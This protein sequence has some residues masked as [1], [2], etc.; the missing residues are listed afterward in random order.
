M[1]RFVD[2]TSSFADLYGRGCCRQRVGRKRS[3]SIG[4]GHPVPHFKD[5]AKDPYYGEWEIG[6][7][8]ACWRIIR[9]GCVLCGSA[10]VV[11]SID[12]LDDK[13]QGVT[14]GAVRAIDELTKFDIRVTLDNGVY[15]DFFCASSDDDEWFHVFGP[16]NIVVK[17]SSDGWKIGK[18]NQPWP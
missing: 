1:T 11:D 2:A 4:F 7:Y 12:E 9:A 18:S 14:L 8:S 10:D 13:L 16:D 6:T 5:L 3:L 15:I 17:V